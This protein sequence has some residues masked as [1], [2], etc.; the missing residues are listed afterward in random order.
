MGKRQ[1]VFDG[2][3][4]ALYLPAGNA[5]TFTAESVCEIAECRAPSEAQLQAKL[6]TPGEVV[7]SLAWRRKCFTPDS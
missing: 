3:P 6:I 4:Y 1:N 2:F 5:A 7:S